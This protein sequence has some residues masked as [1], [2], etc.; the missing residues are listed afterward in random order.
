MTP[1]GYYAERFREVLSDERPNLLPG[2]VALSSP[3]PAW[4]E[5]FRV[6]RPNHSGESLLVVDRQDTIEIAWL[7]LPCSGPAEYHWIERSERD[8]N[9]VQR[10]VSAVVAILDDQIR[11]VIVRR[12]LLWIKQRDRGF[13][14]RQSDPVPKGDIVCEVYW[15]R[16]LPNQSS[17]PTLASGTSPAGQEPR[18][19]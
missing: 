1:L 17:E 13:L 15:N 16:D 14:I 7:G 9:L 4:I 6:R 10:A 12:S 19:P 5:V 3:D 2:F 11:V 18:L 8:A